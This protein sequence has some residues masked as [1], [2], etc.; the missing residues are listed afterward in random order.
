MG[1]QSEARDLFLI[2]NVVIVFGTHRQYQ[3]F[4]GDIFPGTGVAKA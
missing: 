2:F 1:F 4:T 3:M